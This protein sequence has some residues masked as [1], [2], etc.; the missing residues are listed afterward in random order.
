VSPKDPPGAETSKRVPDSA[1]APACAEPVRFYEDA[2]T[3]APA[4]ARLYARWRALGARAK[5]TH[6]IALCER[7]G[8]RP[9]GTLEVGCGDGALLSELRRR[10][11]G[12]WLHGVE[13]APAAVAIARARDEIASVE[14][15]DGAHLP[16]D[17]GAYELGIVSHVLEHVSDPPALLGEVARVCEVVL[18]EVPLEDNLSARRP[19]KRALGREVGHLQRLNRSAARALVARAGLRVVCELEDPLGLE[20][21]RFFAKGAIA[22]ARASA[23]WA[24]RA[25]LYRC[26]PALA[27]RL[28]T[29]HYACLCLPA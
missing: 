26:A 18:V 19:A 23:K 11:F 21:Q 2:Y 17:D 29:V 8:V 13:I 28:F 10:G 6:A 16:A 4:E 25:G 9:R 14:C 3:H 5:A 27:R 15:Y 22:R 12:G 20:A 1:G 24:V 7:A